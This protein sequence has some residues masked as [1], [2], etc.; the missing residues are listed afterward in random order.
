M[1]VLVFIII[2]HS[3]PYTCMSQ[4]YHAVCGRITLQ[5]S[6]LYST[7]LSRIVVD[8]FINILV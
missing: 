7:C 2:I 5:L 4:P 6:V 1:I 3:R 8:F